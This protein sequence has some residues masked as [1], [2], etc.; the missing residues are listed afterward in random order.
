MEK[1]SKKIIP[2]G[3]RLWN[4]AKNLIPGGTQLLSK[5][6]EMFLPDGWPSYYKKAKGVEV[7]DLSGRKFIDMSYM[8]LGA[9][10]LGYSDPDVNKAVSKVLNNGVVS[11]LNTPFDVELAEL[12][13]KLHPWAGQ[14]K[15][16]RTGGEAM[17]VAVR[18]A[19]AYTDRDKIVFCGYHGWHDWYLAANLAH[20]KN[21]DGHLLPGLFPRGVPRALKGTAF[22][23]HY[24]KFSEL[25]R[26]AARHKKTIAAVVIEPM[27]HHEPED[28]FLKKVRN[29]VSKIGAVLIFD[30]ITIGFR[31]NIGGVHLLYKVNPDI[32]VFAKGISN[33]HPMAAIIGKKRVMDAAETSF[34]S[35]TY[36]TEAVGPAAVIATIK[37][38]QRLNVPAHLKKIGEKISEGWKIR[39]ANYGLKINILGPEPLITFSFDYGSKNQIL[40]TIFTQEMLKRGFLAG[41]SVYVSYA[42][43]DSHV[44]KYL[45]AI[46]EVFAIVKKSVDSKN[47]KKFLKGPVARSG[48]KRLT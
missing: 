24:N 12:L 35:S 29:L 15:F 21:L 7:W 41:P 33:G 32:A 6:A 28:D 18:I 40:K 26:I 39:A 22:T 10:T 47:P 2:K 8:S 23:F 9:A 13:C 27:R 19:R 11:T 48:F 36:W 44:K 43:K 20:K 17:T 1:S 16:A 38:M 34:I 30:E 14:V 37:K 42:H 45:K 46:D 25:E 5:R 4:R 3:V 31:K